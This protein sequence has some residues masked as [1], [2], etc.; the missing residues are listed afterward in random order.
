MLGRLTARGLIFWHHPRG[1]FRR[2]SCTPVHRRPG[3]RTDQ[4]AQTRPRTA[5]QTWNP[6]AVRHGEL[7]LRSPPSSKHD[8]NCRRNSAPISP[9][10]GSRILRCKGKPNGRSPPHTRCPLPRGTGWTD[11]L[12]VP[13]TTIAELSSSKAV[14]PTSAAS[15]CACSPGLSW[16][17]RGGAAPANAAPVR[18]TESVRIVDDIDISLFW[19]GPA[20]TE[21]DAHFCEHLSFN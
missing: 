16:A 13:V 14:S 1:S 6:H 9:V 19:R 15:S 8:S 3:G 21:D 11:R 18:R 20:A 17:K 12:R 2:T 7:R 10:R 4:G 5:A